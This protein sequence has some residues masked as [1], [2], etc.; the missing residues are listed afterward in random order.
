M[1]GF[2]AQKWRPWRLGPPDIRSIGPAQAQACAQIHAESFAHAWSVAEFETLL[3]GR[4][5]TAEAATVNSPWAQSWERVW[6][7]P[8]RLAGFVLS[9]RV[10]DEAEILTI[11][12]ALQFRR[13]G[14]GGAL[15]AAHLATLTSQGIKTLFLEVEAGNAAALALY[16]GF[17]FYQVGARKGYYAKPGGSAAAALVLRRDFV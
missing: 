7:Q 1:S 17:G 5:V 4:D 6:R 15:L 12:V 13:R 2:F 9:R 16:G 14:I 11:A 10:L 3:A 8:P